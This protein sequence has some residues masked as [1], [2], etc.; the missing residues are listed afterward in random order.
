MEQ[1]VT[2]QPYSRRYVV[3]DAVQQALHGLR[4]DGEHTLVIKNVVG[5]VV[6]SLLVTV[7]TYRTHPTD[8]L[9]SR[10]FRLGKSKVVRY[11]SR[12]AANDAVR[13]LERRIGFRLQR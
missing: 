4:D 9:P 2:L 3:E 12:Q 11:D 10:T 5:D 8:V 7:S 6:L 1:T 13:R